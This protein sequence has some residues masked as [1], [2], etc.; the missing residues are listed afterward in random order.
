MAIPIVLVDEESRDILQRVV[1][2]TGML[3]NLNI[4]A[5][6]LQRNLDLCVLRK[7]TARPQSQFPHSCVCERS[8]YSHVRQTEIAHRNMN[9]RTGIVAAQFLFWE[10][11]FRIFGIMSLQCVRSFLFQHI[12]CPFRPCRFNIHIVGHHLVLLKFSLYFS[13]AY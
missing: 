12:S 3:V 2:K 9:I 4:K 7:G 6:A 5:S 10:Y 13:V 11:F 8:I 1:D